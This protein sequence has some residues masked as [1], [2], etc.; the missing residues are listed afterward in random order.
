[1]NVY[2]YCITQLFCYGLSPVQCQATSWGNGGWCYIPCSPAT[3]DRACWLCW[4]GWLY[5]LQGSNHEVPGKQWALHWHGW[6]CWSVIIHNSKVHGANMGPTWGWQDPGGP[7]VGHV[8]LAIWDSNAGAACICDMNVVNRCINTCKSQ[9][10]PL[11]L[12]TFG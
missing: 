8:N 2:D 9:W 7:H 10:R 6:L 3:L 4:P 11:R 12:T 5:H 1:M